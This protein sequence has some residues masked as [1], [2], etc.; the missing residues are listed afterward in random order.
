M[1]RQGGRDRGV[2]QIVVQGDNG[3]LEETGNR[4][5]EELL[6]GCRGGVSRIW[7]HTGGCS[8]CVL[9]VLQVVSSGRRGEG[10]R[11]GTGV[12]GHILGNAL[13]AG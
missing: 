7:M 10:G 9:R 2:S 13:E 8:W 11:T 1:L 12:L 4:L 5:A 3:R 6:V